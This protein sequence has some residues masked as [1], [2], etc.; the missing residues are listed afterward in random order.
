MQL[1]RLDLS[2]AELEMLPVLISEEDRPLVVRVSDA[3]TVTALAGVAGD[4]EGSWGVW[5]EPGE[6]YGI[7]ALARDVR[8]LAQLIELDHLVTK[9]KL[10]EE[11]RFEDYVTPCTRF[12]TDALADADKAIAAKRDYTRGYERKGAA[13]EALGRSADARAAAS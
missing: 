5:L 11:D 3:D 12:E 7:G 1:A 6:D 10:S 4:W 9:A 13:L 8:T 2:C